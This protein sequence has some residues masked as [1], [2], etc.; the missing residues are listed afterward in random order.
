MSE[1]LKRFWNGY[2]I[3]IAIIKLRRLT[4]SKHAEVVQ[5]PQSMHTCF[6]QEVDILTIKCESMDIKR[7]GESL[8]KIKKVISRCKNILINQKHAFMGDK[9]CFLDSFFATAVCP[10][11]AGCYVSPLLPTVLTTQQRSSFHPVSN[12][13]RT[14]ERKQRWI[15][16]RNKLFDNQAKNVAV[17]EA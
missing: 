12:Y 1:V 13:Q 6:H 7:E 8:Y 2:I 10:S 16:W 15:I 17:K 11:S 14:K 3:N 9:Y 4:Q 5:S